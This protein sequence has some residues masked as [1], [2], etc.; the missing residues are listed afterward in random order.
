MFP[1]SDV[2]EPRG[3]DHGDLPGKGV[4]AGA[5]DTHDGNAERHQ[6]KLSQGQGGQNDKEKPEKPVGGNSTYFKPTGEKPNGD[7]PKKEKPSNGKLNTE[8]PNAGSQQ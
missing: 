8:R 1:P 3:R 4:D 6:S 5:E 7:N 2:A